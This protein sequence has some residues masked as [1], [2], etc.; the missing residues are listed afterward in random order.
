MK[1]PDALPQH[2]SM[3]RVPQIANHSCGGFRFDSG[4]CDF[5]RLAVFVGQDCLIG[6]VSLMLQNLH[7]PSS[8]LVANEGFLVGAIHAV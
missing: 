2:S 7:R 3:D 5:E 8:V 4:C 1:V 6:I